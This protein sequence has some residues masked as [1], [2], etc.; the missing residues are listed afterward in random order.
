MA[1]VYTLKSFLTPYYFCPKS[2]DSPD[3]FRN[4]LDSACSHITSSTINKCNQAPKVAC[5]LLIS[6][7]RDPSSDEV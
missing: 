4:A 3:L 6:V 5:D 2:V 1:A 7:R